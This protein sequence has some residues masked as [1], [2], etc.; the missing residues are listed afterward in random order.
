LG[1]L[2]CENEIVNDYSSSLSSNRERN[3]ALM[4]QY[5]NVLNGTDEKLG[6]GAGNEAKECHLGTKIQRYKSYI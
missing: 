5:L 1:I 2:I 4:L 6:R 3:H